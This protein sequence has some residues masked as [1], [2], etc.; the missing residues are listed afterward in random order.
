MTTVPAPLP[1]PDAS[2]PPGPIGLQYR[3]LLDSSRTMLA[4]DEAGCLELTGLRP[5]ALIQNRDRAFA[6]LIHPDDRELASR[7]I[8]ARLR[9]RLPFAVRYRLRIVEGTDAWV[10]DQGRG[11]YDAAGRITGIYGLIT[12]IDDFERQSNDV[13]SLQLAI[14]DTNDEAIVGGTLSGTIMVWNQGAEHLFGYPRGEAI[15]QPISLIE[16][17]DR[18]DEIAETNRQIQAG[19]SV[20]RLVTERV[21]RDGRRIPVALTLRPVRNATGQVMGVATLARDLTERHQMA[22][23]LAESETQYRQMMA[24]LPVGVYLHDGERIL[25]ANQAFADLMHAARPEDLVGRLVMDL[26]YLDDQDIMAERIAGVLAGGP[27]TLPLEIIMVR[28]DN[29]HVEVESRGGPVRYQGQPAVQGVVVDITERQAER[30]ARIESEGRFRALVENAT[31]WLWETDAKLHFTYTSPTVLDVLHYAPELMLGR[32][33]LDFLVPEERHRVRSTLLAQARGGGRVAGLTARFRASG[34]DEQVVVLETGATGEARGDGYFVGFRGVSRDV[35]ERVQ[36]QEKLAASERFQ[37]QVLDTLPEG[38]F[39]VDAAGTEVNVNPAGRRLWQGTADGPA[40]SRYRGWSADGR[41]LRPEDWPLAR[42]LATRQAVPAE[43]LRIQCFDGSTRM[44]EATAVPLTDASGK[45][46]GA[47]SV[48]ADISA[49][50]T[51][52][53][54]VQRVVDTSPNLIYLYDLRQERLIYV[55]PR[56]ATILGAPLDPQVEPSFNARLDP[57]DA[58]KLQS[59]RERQRASREGD[60]LEVTFRLRHATGRWVL[61][62]SRERI[63]STTPEGEPWQIIGTASDITQQQE[64]LDALLR[65]E[66]QLAEAEALAHL[67]SFEIDVAAGQA[68]LSAEACRLI[69][70]DARPAQLDPAQVAALVHPDDQVLLEAGRERLLTA[71]E[72]VEATLRLALPSGAIKHVSVIA[73]PVTNALGRVTRVVG[74]GLDVTQQREAEAAER[75]ARTLAE[76]LVAAA[77]ALGRTRRPEELGQRVLENVTRLVPQANAASLLLV[78]YGVAR[79]LA[80]R[81]FPAGVAAA[82]EEMSVAEVPALHEMAEARRPVLRQDARAVRPTGHLE[83]STRRGY[84]GA[85]ILAGRRLLGFIQV[86]SDQVGAFGERDVDNLQALAGQAAIALDNVLLLGQLRSAA[87]VANDLAVESE[88]ASQLQANFLARISHELRTPLTSMLAVM[89]MM[90]NPKYSSASRPDLLAGAQESARRMLAALNDLTAM[91]PNAAGRVGVALAAVPVGPALERAAGALRARAHAKGLSLEIDPLP[92]ALPSAQADAAKLDRI[93]GA[94]VEN[95]VQVSKTGG[96]RLQASLSDQFGEK[97]P[98]VV[99]TVRDTGPGFA[100]EQQSTLLQPSTQRLKRGGPDLSLSIARR[101]TELMGGTLLAE[102]DGPGRGSAFSV[103]LP[104]WKGAPPEK[105][106]TS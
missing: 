88:H 102:S 33:L 61:L 5:E 30:I 24:L 86:F 39:V 49:L 64:A 13:L 26:V 29:S 106:S 57:E 103:C 45:V 82:G 9:Q 8:R 41:A 2:P 66:A 99:L 62:R 32:S 98:Y 22:A 55:N 10:L 87:E 14:L 56:A 95:A 47:L 25:F 104:A 15:G 44:V 67:G 94:L 59:H 17:F 97:R 43:V 93:L 16:P 19:Q 35:T 7:T 23:A 3:G 4:L 81:G 53:R 46:T 89:E 20:D 51:A 79:V 38:V 31:D 28:L 74:A 21:A 50:H 48:M 84:L 58:A 37:R 69:E 60:E 11:E 70:R 78:E 75:A 83:W 54:F 12:N 91:D 1:R 27:P 36:D 77:V 65:S 63:F 101:L 34:D 40:T 42:A 76:A 71:R 18:A 73:Y 96:V 80:A 92:E 72:R 105:P 52:Q 6:D 68:Q 100:P 90:T 85:P